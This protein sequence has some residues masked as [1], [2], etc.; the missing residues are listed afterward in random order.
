[1]LFRLAVYIFVGVA[2][3]Y[4]GAI[5]W[6]NVL[7]PAFLGPLRAQG[8]AAL[9]NVGFLVPALLVVLLA[10][11]LFP[12][13]ARLGTV[14]LAFLA[15]VGAAVAVGGA[16]TGTLLPQGWAAIDTLSPAAVSP[17]TGETGFERAGNGVILLL[18][19]ISTLTYFRFGVLRTPTGE[20]RRDRLTT[21]LAGIGQFF[22]ALTFGAMYAGA[23][24]ASLVILA[25]RLQF[26]LNVVSGFLSAGGLT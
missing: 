15:G 5:A 23:L 6:H 3:G 8:L 17:L 21:V 18:G 25:E 4:A 7:A 22:I 1:V 13:T 24:A 10:F 12:A 2:A 11:K 20:L 16:I 9:S 19:T 26:V 14:S